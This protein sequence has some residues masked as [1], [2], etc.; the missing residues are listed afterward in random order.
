MHLLRST[1]A[2]TLSAGDLYRIRASLAITS[3]AT[4]QQYNSIIW[5][6]SKYTLDDVVAIY[7]PENTIYFGRIEAIIAHSENGAVIKAVL[8]ISWFEVFHKATDT[9]LGTYRKS[10]KY[11]FLPPQTLV[12]HV[13]VVEHMTQ[14]NLY[15]IHPHFCRYYSK[16]IKNKHY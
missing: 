11:D 3:S 13:L 6:Y 8:K 7:A 9:S 16:Y 14:E 15:H 1:V 4:L 5:D 10:T 2:V 12:G